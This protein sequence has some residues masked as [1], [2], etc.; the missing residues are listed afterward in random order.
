LLGTWRSEQG[1]T[2]AFKSNGFVVY[3]GRRYHYAAGNGA[4]QI[5]NR[6]VFRQLP[7]RIFDGKLTV[8]ENGVD[9][10]YTRD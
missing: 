7:Y 2:I 6:K 9:T 8:T 1:A 5:K 4:I 3:K 10:I